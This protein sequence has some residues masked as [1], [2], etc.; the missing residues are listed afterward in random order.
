MRLI[1]CALFWPDTILSTGSQFV[2]F[3]GGWGSLNFMELAMPTTLIKSRL[4]AFNLQQGLCIYCEL[5][6]WIDNPKAFAEKYKITIKGAALFKC[7][8]EH[9]LAR[10]DGGKDGESNIV[11]ACHYCNQHRHKCKSAKEPMSYKLH[12]SKRLEKGKWNS[13]IISR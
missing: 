6:M 8:A 3:K 9:L 4:K 5:P 13:G 10:K 1:V 11:A 2:L 7:T 12:V